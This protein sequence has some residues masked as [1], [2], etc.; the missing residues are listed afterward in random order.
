MHQS[1]YFRD[2]Y[3]LCRASLQSYCIATPCHTIEIV[4]QCFHIW[5]QIDETPYPG[6]NCVYLAGMKGGGPG[7]LLIRQEIP[8]DCLLSKEQNS[9]VQCA[10]ISLL[11]VILRK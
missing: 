1:S 10:I 4:E 2:F 6:D 9:Q 7:L 3:V 11:P 8:G 5:L